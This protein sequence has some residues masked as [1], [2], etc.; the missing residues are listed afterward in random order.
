MPR[1]LATLC[2]PWFC[3]WNFYDRSPD[4]YSSCPALGFSI[5]QSR[6]VFPV[7]FPSQA[8]T[9]QFSVDLGVSLGHLSF[10]LR[11][12]YPAWFMDKNLFAI[13][14]VVMK[15]ADVPFCVVST[16]HGRVLLRILRFAGVT[17]S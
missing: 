3:A 8:R 14:M 5:K 16:A 2:K 9:T 11:S 7:P 15:V 10:H 13:D 6:A 4:R 12:R 17:M 1:L